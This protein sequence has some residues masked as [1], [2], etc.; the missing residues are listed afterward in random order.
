[1]EEPKQE[2]FGIKHLLMLLAS[3]AISVLIIVFNKQLRELE[4]FGYI[5]IFL[6]MFLGNATVLVPVPILA[7]LNILLGGIFSS[8][9]LL[10]L[11]VGVAS[12]LGELVGYLAGYSGSGIVKSSKV[13]K[14]IELQVEKYGLWAIFFLALIPNPLFDVA[15]L[16]AGALGIKWWKFLIAVTAGKTIR[17]IVFAYI[18]YTGGLL[19]SK[20]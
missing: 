17:A 8:P 13:Y 10:G 11:T 1:M 12:S 20:G 16:A 3:I 4:Q 2:K 6:L 5:G 19:F 14:K 18:G 15:G 7:P 9:L